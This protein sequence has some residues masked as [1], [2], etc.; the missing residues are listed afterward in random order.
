MDS[1]QTRTQI[2][3]VR[4]LTKKYGP[5][6]KERQLSFPDVMDIIAYYED[7]GENQAVIDAEQKVVEMQDKLSRAQGATGGLQ[8]RINNLEAQVSEM[9]NVKANNATLARIANHAADMVAY[10]VK[11][12][13][14]Y[15]D[16]NGEALQDLPLFVRL[17]QEIGE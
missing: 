1:K 13:N 7:D 9:A 10:V 3:E 5:L 12:N 6:V 15:L 17:V 11:P 8:K 16:G 2:K 4:D 14:N